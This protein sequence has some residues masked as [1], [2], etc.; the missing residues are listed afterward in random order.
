MIV[1]SLVPFHAN[2]LNNKSTYYAFEN[3]TID[4]FI[5]QKPQGFAFTKIGSAIKITQNDP[6]KIILIKGLFTINSEAI[7]SNCNFKL[8]PDASIIVHD[9]ANANFD[10]TFSRCT[11][12][13][14][15]HEYMWRGIICETGAGININNQSV[16]EEAQCGISVNNG[17]F[18]F[19]QCNL[20]A[21]YIGAKIENT[22][23]N[24]DCRIKRMDFGCNDLN[25]GLPINLIAPYAGM[26]TKNS[27]QIFNSSNILLGNIG[28][29]NN[30]FQNTFHHINNAVYINNSNVDVFHNRFEDIQR[31][32]NAGT[33]IAIEATKG[34]PAMNV[35]IGD[36]DVWNL[37]K[38]N[39]FT[40]CRIGIHAHH[41]TNLIAGFNTFTDIR[42]TLGTFDNGLTET[43]IQVNNLKQNFIRINDNTFNNFETGVKEAPTI[44]VKF[45]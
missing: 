27:L 35:N 23:G 38:S 4:D 10:A 15:N 16:I 13:T 17:D 22:I 31:Y 36:M 20:N 6:Q 2:C 1:F 43:A 29:N 11:L 8:A 9:I 33:G 24:N 41:N 5:Y 18:F 25:T 32:D 7:F 37:K 40:R 44:I 19:D 45:K 30:I 26:K 28:M 3:L 42:N 34:S 39:S 14:S 12:N 21:C